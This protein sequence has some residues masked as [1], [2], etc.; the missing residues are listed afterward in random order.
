MPKG[1]HVTVWVIM[2][3]E[4][5]YDGQIDCLQFHVSSTLKKAEAYMRR[6]YM[7]PYSWWQVHSYV[8]DNDHEKDWDDEQVHFYNNRGKSL[9]KAPHKQAMRAFEKANAAGELLPYE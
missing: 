6:L 3:Y 4:Y 8:I 9:K 2:H 5:F 1:Q 7:A